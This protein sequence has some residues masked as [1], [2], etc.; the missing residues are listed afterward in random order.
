[1]MNPQVSSVPAASLV[2]VC[3]YF[4][5]LFLIL[6]RFPQPPSPDVCI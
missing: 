3:V 2:R 6:F 1:M 5:P 4:V